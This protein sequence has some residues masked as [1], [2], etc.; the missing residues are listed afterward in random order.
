MRENER[1]VTEPQ[2]SMIR[3]LLSAL[4][5]SNL[6]EVSEAPPSSAI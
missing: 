4:L 5:L 2:S 3:L 6:D 1:L